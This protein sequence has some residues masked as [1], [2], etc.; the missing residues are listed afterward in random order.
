MQ[1]N[2][3]ICQAQPNGFVKSAK[4]SIVESG[5]FEGVM[6]GDFLGF[7]SDSHGDIVANYQ[8]VAGIIV[9]WLTIQSPFRRTNAT[10]Q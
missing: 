7:E 4:R 8:D 2:S 10:S 5:F 1:P 3:C 9:A 6:E